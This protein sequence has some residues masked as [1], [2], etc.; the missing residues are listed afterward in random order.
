[1]CRFSLTHSMQVLEGFQWTF[2]QAWQIVGQG[3]TDH[4]CWASDWVNLSTRE[5]LRD[6][7]GV[8][9]TWG[10][11]APINGAQTWGWKL[12][13]SAARGS[14]HSSRAEQR[15]TR[16]QHLVTE[17]PLPRSRGRCCISL[18]VLPSILY[19]YTLRAWPFD[20]VKWGKEKGENSTLTFEKYT[21][22]VD[23]QTRK[24][25]APK[26]WTSNQTWM[27]N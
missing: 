4:C 15:S 12:K 13:P 9:A 11:I 21:C 17:T 10:K 18:C 26:L 7:A 8:F 19:Y 5:K 23:L 25:G 14:D 1:M 20:V 3:S 2:A 27:W 22:A 24:P 6:P 16:G